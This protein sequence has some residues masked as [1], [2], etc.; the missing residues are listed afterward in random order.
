[1][2]KYRNTEERY[3]SYYLDELVEKEL[4]EGYTYEVVNFELTPK[5]TFPYT[6]VTKLKTK[7]KVEEKEKTLFQ[8]MTYT[9][10]FIINF[11]PKAAHIAN[12]PH[13]LPI[14]ITSKGTMTCYVDVKPSFGRATN[15]TNWTFPIK[16]KI[17]Y[18][19]HRIYV[20]KIVPFELFEKTFVPKKV[21]EEHI[22]KKD[23][24]SGKKGESKFK[25][26]IVLIDDWL[27]TL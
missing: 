9:P 15:S 5:Y 27:K 25:N 18:H 22:Y 8:P 10:D 23:C 17:M 13:K 14:F 2:N 1:M 11:E 7:T 20:Q 19:L 21:L 26:D 6:K 24:K 4:I 16:Q 12:S 3:F